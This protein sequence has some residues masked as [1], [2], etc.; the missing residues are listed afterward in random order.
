MPLQ[1]RAD[2]RVKLAE[3]LLLKQTPVVLVGVP[4]MA[5]ELHVNVPGLLPWRVLLGGWAAS[6]P[7]GSEVG[8][9]CCLKMFSWG[10]RAATGPLPMGASPAWDS[11]ADR[12]SIFNDMRSSRSRGFCVGS[13]AA[14]K[15]TAS[16]P[17]WPACHASRRPKSSSPKVSQHC[18]AS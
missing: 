9:Q 2:P 8:K 4:I 10:R 11:E 13:H 7:L 1:L 17:Q 16:G 5:V 15:E 12:T 14:L 6:R 3:Q 18:K